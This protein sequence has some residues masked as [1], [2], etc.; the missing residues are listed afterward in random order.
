MSVPLS[1]TGPMDER[2][3][4]Y[5]ADIKNEFTRIQRFGY[6]DSS[7]VSGGGGRGQGQGQGD[8][9]RAGLNVNGK[10]SYHTLSL[11]LAGMYPTLTSIYRVTHSIVDPFTI[12]LTRSF[13]LMLTNS[14]IFSYIRLITHSHCNSLSHSS[15]HLLTTFPLHQNIKISCSNSLIT[16]HHNTTTLQHYTADDG[17]ALS[18]MVKKAQR[19]L[20]N[21]LKDQKNAHKTS[22]TAKPRYHVVNNENYYN[23]QNEILS[24]SDSDSDSDSDG[25][26]DHDRKM[27]SNKNRNLDQDN[28]SKGRKETK[29]DRQEE[30]K[31]IKL[32]NQKSSHRK[33]GKFPADYTGPTG[34][35]HAR[36]HGQGADKE[37][38]YAGGTYA[39]YLR[40]IVQYMI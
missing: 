23:N 30:G 13:S 7:S 33:G 38:C 19:G 31:S 28:K 22:S 6:T 34:L 29:K 21:A 40:C 36:G 35:L 37:T 9:G 10:L 3:L 15:S 11:S 18:E 14:F 4:Q 8:G 5:L 24:G 20:R 39:L 1:S 17:E 26:V 2:M 27:K 25:S 12:S 32:K 16:H